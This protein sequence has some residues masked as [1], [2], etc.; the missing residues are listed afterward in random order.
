MPCVFVGGGGVHQTG[1][2]IKFLISF[3]LIAFHFNIFYLIFVISQVDLVF[4]YI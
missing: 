2:S 3:S 1:K 4:F